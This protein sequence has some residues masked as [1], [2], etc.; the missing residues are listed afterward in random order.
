M[1]GKQI[2][3]IIL[4]GFL[5]LYISCGIRR[6]TFVRTPVEVKTDIGFQIKRRP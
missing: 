4:I 5:H 3:Q 1:G 2:E 6:D